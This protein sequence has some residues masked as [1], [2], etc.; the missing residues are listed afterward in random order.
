MESVIYQY[1]L[2]CEQLKRLLTQY[3]DVPAIFNREAPDS[4]D[5]LWTNPQYPRLIFELSMQED[6]ERKTSGTLLID[7]YFNTDGGIFIEEAE[8]IIRT[9]IDGYFFSSENE[10]LAALWRRSDPFAEPSEGNRINGIT[11]IFDVVSFPSQ[12]TSFPCPVQAIDAYLKKLFPEYKVL[13]NDD[14][15]GTW[16]ATDKSPAIYTRLQRIDPGSSPSTYAV[17][18]YN[19]VLMV[20]VIAPSPNVRNSVL[21]QIVEHMQADVQVIMP[22]DAPMFVQ[23]IALSTGADQLKTGQ[24][25]ITGCYG[26][27]RTEQETS[28]L[29]HIILSQREV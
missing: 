3:N 7:F 12:R 10:T 2:H 8:P 22:D 4:I 17:T 15:V 26:L 29:E 19:A 27:L 18:W 21:K 16:K 1:L 20:H 9:L 11:I 5:E 28:K 13:G 24:L 25:A 14:L 23:R 6:P